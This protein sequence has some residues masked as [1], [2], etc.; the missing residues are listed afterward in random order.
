MSTSLPRIEEKIAEEDILESPPQVEVAQ[1]KVYSLKMKHNYI[2][3]D[4]IESSTYQRD[5]EFVT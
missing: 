2:Q 3:S 5:D 1:S 4:S